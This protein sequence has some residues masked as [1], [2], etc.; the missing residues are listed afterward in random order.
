M[1]SF[2]IDLLEH[3]LKTKQIH[4]YIFLQQYF[5]KV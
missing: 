3:N 2:I 1:Y 5:I 4:K